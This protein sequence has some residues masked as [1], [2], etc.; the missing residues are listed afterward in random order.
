MVIPGNAQHK[1]NRDQQQ[2]SFGIS[3]LE[4]REFVSY[5]GALAVLADGMGG[6]SHGKN[7]SQTAVKTMLNSYAG[8]HKEE[9]ISK[10]LYRSLLEANAGVLEIASEMNEPGQVGTTF[11]A[12]VVHLN[13]LYWISVGDSRI[14]LLRNNRLIQLTADHT[15]E[16]ELL[17]DA[18]NGMICKDDAKRNPDRHVLTSYLGLAGLDE[19]DRNI[20]PFLLRHNDKILLCSDGLY[21]SIMEDEIIENINGSPQ[22]SSERLVDY[23]ISRNY[24]N[25]DNVSVVILDYRERAET[26]PSLI[27][28][29]SKWFK[30]TR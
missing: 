11:A 4:D 6:M 21:K 19:I 18:A 2:D 28:K 9:G 26:R 24:R 7:A 16:K 15:Y 23:V 25:Q 17:R 20:R 29:I 3:N 27:E 1:G 12:A 30:I 8:K 22:S 13:M 5:G 14:Y 10:A